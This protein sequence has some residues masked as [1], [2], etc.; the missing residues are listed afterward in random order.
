[1]VVVLD[2]L[3]CSERLAFILH[4]VFGVPFELLAATLKRSPEAA[5]QL[6]SRARRKARAAVKLPAGNLTP[7]WRVVDAFLAAARDGDF[8]RLVALLIPTTRSARTLASSPSDSKSAKQTPPDATPPLRRAADLRVPQSFI[9]GTTGF[10]SMSAGGPLAAA[11]MTALDGGLDVITVPFHSDKRE[12][13]KLTALHRR[14]T[15]VHDASD[16][17]IGGRAAVKWA[18]R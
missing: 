18:P 12:R 8:D 1:M 6:A 13:G 16:C 15:R 14:C 11:G 4:D 9:R 5:R 17:Q 3:N 7:D 2:T 10:D